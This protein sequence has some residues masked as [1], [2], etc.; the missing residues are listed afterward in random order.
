MTNPLTVAMNAL[1]EDF[2]RDVLQAIRDSRVAD[3]IA[4]SKNTDR[5]ARGPARNTA[6]ANPPPPEPTPGETRRAMIGEVLRRAPRKHRS[7]GTGSLG[8][9]AG[10]WATYVA[11]TLHAGQLRREGAGREA[12]YW[13]A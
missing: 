1:I 2:G 7:S 4:A 5:P 8:F 3:V 6:A 13:A 12:R 9:A 11:R 10:Q